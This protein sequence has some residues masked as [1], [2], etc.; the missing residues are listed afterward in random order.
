MRFLLLLILFLPTVSH[1]IV[2][3]NFL[4]PIGG[5]EGIT[6]N[7]GIARRASVGN[8]IYNP[9]GLAYIST[10][11]VSVS[12]SAFSQNWIDVDID[13]NSEKIKY[14]QT[15]PSQITTVYHDD[16]INYAF[17]IL[18]PKVS[19]FKTSFTLDEVNSEVNYEDQETYLGPT[20]SIKVSDKLSIGASL[21]G[22]KR[23]FSKQENLYMNFVE[24]ELPV[25]AQRFFSL[26]IS[27]ISAVGN[28]GISYAPRDNLKFGLNI[29]S[30]KV[31]LSSTFE[32]KIFFTAS[33]DST[34]SNTKNGDASFTAPG[35]L[36]FGLEY[37][38]SDKLK[39]LLDVGYQLSQFSL[40]VK[41]D[42]SGGRA[43][44][45]YNHSYRAHL[46]VEYEKSAKEAYT[47][48][49][50]YNQKNEVN[51]LDFFGATIGYRLREKVADTMIGLFVNKSISKKINN[52]ETNYLMAGLYL[53]STINFM[54]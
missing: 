11:K 52:I 5:I 4:T 42:A 6:G 20:I 22:I 36:S 2:Q 50:S 13:G 39:L 10:H 12:G 30:P 17:S 51:S 45:D 3:N 15:T 14:F 25:T 8:V 19:K 1:S 38:P 31:N 44:Y 37:N 24:N 16:K 53:S 46:G 47:F 41:N 27:G 9:A 34:S 48:G 28:I 49:A 18:V 21:F 40:L 43:F 35:E 32:S 23:D 54:E 26:N 33:N 7:T 29:Q